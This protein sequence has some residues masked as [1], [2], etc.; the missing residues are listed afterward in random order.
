M[1]KVDAAVGDFIGSD[2][3]WG[4]VGVVG[5]VSAVG[6]QRM[7]RGVALVQKRAIEM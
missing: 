3:V 5:E 6:G 4:V 1:M 2:G 7:W